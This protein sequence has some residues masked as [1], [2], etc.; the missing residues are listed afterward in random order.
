MDREWSRLV[1]YKSRLFPVVEK[2]LRLDE[3]AARRYHLASQEI[4]LDRPVL[5][6][7]YGTELPWSDLVFFPLG[8]ECTNLSSYWAYLLGGSGYVIK[9]SQVSVTLLWR[10]V[11]RAGLK[12]IE[13]Q[14]S[15]RKSKPRHVFHM[16]LILELER[17]T[18]LLI[19]NEF[20]PLFVE[21]G[22]LTRPTEP[23]S[24]STNA[25]ITSH[26]CHTVKSIKASNLPH[27]YFETASSQAE[28]S[29]R[30]FWVLK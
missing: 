30:F 28:T 18:G 20:S 16:G 15:R 29:H 25:M 5:P 12:G 1:R 19:L 9:S 22:N 26:R 23:I 24:V 27:W 10:V 14:G 13:N 3:Q 8:S 4:V 17:E 21:A 11:F 2:G 7:F 6:R